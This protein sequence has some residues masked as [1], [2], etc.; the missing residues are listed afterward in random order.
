MGVAWS[1]DGTRM[2]V[3]DARNNRIC[4]FDDKGK[5]VMEFGGLGVAKPLEG[6]A[7]TWDPGELSYPVDVAVDEEGQVYVADFYNDSVSVFDDKG[8][9]VRRFPDPY[10]PTGRGSSGSDGGGIAVTSVAVRGDRVYATDT[11]QV[12]VFDKNGGLIE[13]FGKPGMGPDGLD[14][15]GGIAVDRDGKIYVSDSNHNRVI[16]YTPEGRPLWVTGR[17]VSGLKSQT[18][19]PFVLP[20]GLTIT[21]DGSI[22]VADPL[23]QQLVKLDEDGKVVAQYG[24]R[25]TSE[26]QLNFPMDVASNSDLL[27]V[28]DRQNERAQVVKLST[29]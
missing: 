9:F 20:R 10:K 14:H 16:A 1:Q 13:Q 15:P 8:G 25:G 24:V 28:A 5:P 6:A 18:E 11:Y 29:R 7:R 27:L 4:V 26:G 17:P 3:A 2:Y 22:I 21:S 19:N 23:A 12:F